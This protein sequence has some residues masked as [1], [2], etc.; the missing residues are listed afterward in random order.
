MTV[1][2]DGMAASLKDQE[3]GSQGTSKE[4]NTESREQTAPNI[5]ATRHYTLNVD[6]PY[7]RS[8]YHLAMAEVKKQERDF[9]PEVNTLLPETQTLSEVRNL[10][11]P[12]LLSPVTQLPLV[13][14]AF[15]GP[16]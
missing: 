12:S 3:G 11:Q 10:I 1:M 6:Q 14:Q 8:H 2:D 16:G 15:R 13:W 4:G 7:S 9:T 5:F